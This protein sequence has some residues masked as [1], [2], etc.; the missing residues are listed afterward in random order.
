MV[1][2][3]Q[4]ILLLQNDFC[5]EYNG[6]LIINSYDDY[7][8]E[9]GDKNVVVE[10]KNDDDNEIF[11]HELVGKIYKLDEILLSNNIHLLSKI[12]KTVEDY[13]DEHKEPK[14]IFV[15]LENNITHY[16]D[17]IEHLFD[18]S[19]NYS[20]KELLVV[21]NLDKELKK[22]NQTRVKKALNY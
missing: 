7:S 13:F 10:F 19:F 11:D 22:Q 2:F 1:S 5:I 6:S 8:F 17:V 21:K 16:S 9:S 18:G 3:K 12:I 20:I 15:S 14:Y 4:A